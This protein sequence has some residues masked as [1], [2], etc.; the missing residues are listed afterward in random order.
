MLPTSAYLGVGGGDSST[1][2]GGGGVVTLRCRAANAHGVVL[3]RDVTLQP[4]PDVSW[5]PVVTAA[6]AAAGGVAALTCGATRHAQYVRVAA[7]YRADRM[8]TIDAPTP[9]SR[10]IMAGNSLLVRG[11]S[12]ADIGAYSCLARH[13]LSGQT[14]RS[15]PATLTLSPSDASTAPRLLPAAAELSVPA[16]ADVCLPCVASDQPAPHYTWYREWAGRLQ[17][18]EV[19]GGGSGVWWWAQGAALC[20]RS[21]TRASAGA[22]LC[23]AY[24]V[25]GDAT[26]HARLHVTDALRV[27]VAPLVLVCTDYPHSSLTTHMIF[28][29]RSAGGYW[30]QESESPDM[31]KHDFTLIWR[32]YDY[33]ANFIA[34]VV[35]DT[36]STVRFNCSS[37]EAGA[38]L[39]WLHDGAAAGAGAELVVR[40]VA[41]AHR[42]AYQC[43]ARLADHAA[44]ATAEL[45]LG[46]HTLSVR[47]ALPHNSSITQH[48]PC[49]QRII[50]SNWTSIT[51]CSNK[52]NN[53]STA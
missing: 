6:A 10:Y 32:P 25:F 20:L 21:V 42:G 15:A 31:N 47:H 45:R 38:S 44:H 14:K 1:S 29:N 3:S 5:E 7:W 37:S 9:E 24:N 23:K 22:W 11:A 17:P 12:P 18:V 39:S 41:R 30:D 33:F 13:S 35:A 53:R 19:G 4:V 36:G 43:F 40:G 2:V 50:V 16:G 34:R 52:T 26:A 48:M 28:F 49:K 51:L 8:L 27:T 46:G